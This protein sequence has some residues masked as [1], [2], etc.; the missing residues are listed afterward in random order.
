MEAAC[1]RTDVEAKRYTGG[2]WRCRCME[3][4]SSGDALQACC[5]YLPQD[6]WSSGRRAVRVARRRYG[7]MQLWRHAVGEEVW[8]YG[9][10]LRA[11]R[12]G[13]VEV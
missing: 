1:R 11:C 13:G 9:G 7:V 8:R 5:L 10:G 3:L 6:L 4:G 2:G 12:R